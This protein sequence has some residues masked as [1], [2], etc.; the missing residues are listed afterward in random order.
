MATRSFLVLC[1]LPLA[2]VACVAT[3]NL[4]DPQATDGGSGGV[5][6]E[7]TTPAESETDADPTG[8]S[9]ADDA[10]HAD[11]IE[12]VWSCPSDD[13]VCLP[14]GLCVPC[15]GLGESPAAAE[16]GH[17][18]GGLVQD[19][20]GTM[21]L[22]QPAD[23]CLTPGDICGYSG[24]TQQCCNGS[25]CNPD[26]DL[27]ES[28]GSTDHGSCADFTP[29]PA[30]CPD[31]GDASASITPEFVNGFEYAEEAS[32][33]VVSLLGESTVGLTCGDSFPVFSYESSPALSLPFD[34][35]DSVVYTAVDT[36]HPDPEP[37]ISLHDADG[38]LL[39]AYVDAISLSNELPL[40]LSP[41]TVSVSGTGCSGVE[42]GDGLC[43]ADGEMMLSA[44]V[45]INLD[46]GAEVL[47]L[48][49]GGSGTVMTADGETYD[50]IV[51]QADRIVCRDESCLSDEDEPTDRLRMLIVAQ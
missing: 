18:C 51:D 3:Q 40:G 47:T 15:A 5:D 32:C 2:G 33:S 31:V 9:G 11:C 1:T 21:C 19:A 35:G 23:S 36:A 41:F 24:V 13:L 20:S 48:G 37:S 34:V 7:D 43:A 28:D 29:P 17:C 26:T 46:G 49:T 4:G 12:L 45:E 50:V 10:I 39:F 25:V 27:C 8:T 38:V 44:R 6:S 30:E 16:G 14:E 42:V 22:P